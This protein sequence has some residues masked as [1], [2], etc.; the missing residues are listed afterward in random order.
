M[1]HTVSSENLEP[2][3]VDKHICLADDVNLS[4]SVIEILIYCKHN[5]AQYKL[6]L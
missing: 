1:Q 2:E 3:N 6:N 5:K 4:M